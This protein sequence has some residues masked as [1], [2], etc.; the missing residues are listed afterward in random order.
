[1]EITYI[2]ILT[3]TRKSFRTYLGGVYLFAH[4]RGSV[5]SAQR[6]R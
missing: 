6:E 1:M 5:P 2:H 3:H 4:R